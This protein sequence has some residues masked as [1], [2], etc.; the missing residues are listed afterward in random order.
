MLDISFAKRTLG[1]AGLICG[2][3][4]GSFSYTDTNSLFAQDPGSGQNVSP[5]QPTSNASGFRE[6]SGKYL[7]VITDLP[8]SAAIGELPL[9]FEAA[10]PLWGAYFGIEEN[11]WSRWKSTCYLIGD[12]NRFQEAGYFPVNLPP[13]VNGYQLGDQLW[14]MEQP[15]DYY[16]RHLLLHE[17]THW[18]MTRALGNP[19]P[20]WYMEG[21]AEKLATHRWYKGQLQLDV[22]PDRREGFE[23]WGRMLLIK[24]QRGTAQAPTLEGILRYGS[25]A[26]Q[27]VDAYAWSWAALWFL[28]NHPRSAEAMRKLQTAKIGDINSL[29]S[30]LLAQL[31]PHW[32]ELTMSWN[33]WVQQLDYGGDVQRDVP[34]FQTN[35]T[36]E[37][38]DVKLALKVDRGWQDSGLRIKP[39]DQLTIEATGRYQVGSEPEPWWCEPDGVTIDYFSGQPLGKVVGLIVSGDENGVLESE[40]KTEFLAIGSKL[41]CVAKQ[42]GALLL[43]INEPSAQLGDNQGSVDVTITI[44]RP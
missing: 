24:K 39:G 11:E 14:C 13:F 20:P 23:Y 29:T 43:R 6:Y 4:G 17:G 18:F 38:R 22:F 27:Q 37:E 35:V 15:A 8:H 7:T 44:L 31:R 21:M 41:Q 5:L 34:L 32:N 33:A 1:F 26:H 25:T 3:L 19:G 2:V 16:R 28:K 12:R 36:E 9:V 42:E 40:P 10:M 30:K